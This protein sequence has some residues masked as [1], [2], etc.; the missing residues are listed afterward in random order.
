MW[1]IWFATRYCVFDGL[2]LVIC[3]EVLA[4]DALLQTGKI[5]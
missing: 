4:T 2:K 1:I 5:I 3:T